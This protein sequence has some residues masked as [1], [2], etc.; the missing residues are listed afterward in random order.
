MNNVYVDSE[1][2]LN[3]ALNLKKDATNILTT[4]QNECS[5]AITAGN[6]C[7]RVSGLDSSTINASLNKIFTKA[8]DQLML[9]ANFLATNVAQEYDLT[10]Q[11]IAKSFN[12]EFANE[13]ASLLGITIG[14]VAGGATGIGTNISSSSGIIG[15]YTGGSGGSYPSTGSQKT[16]PYPNGNQTGQVNLTDLTAEE[17]A[18]LE[19][20][21]Y[22]WECH[23]G[24][25]GWYKTDPNTGQPILA[26]SNDLNKMY[27]ILGADQNGKYKPTPSTSIN[28]GMTSVPSNISNSNVTETIMMQKGFTKDAD[29]NWVNSDGV[30]VGSGDA[31]IISH[32]YNRFLEN[33]GGDINSAY[34]STQALTDQLIKASANGEPVL[35]RD[36]AGNPYVVTDSNFGLGGNTRNS[37]TTSSN[38]SSH[39]SDDEYFRM[40]GRS[41][42]TSS[43]ISS[44]DSAINANSLKQEQQEYKNYTDTS[45]ANYHLG[46]NATNSHP[47]LSNDEYF[48]MYGRSRDTSSSIS[49]RDSAINAN[50]LK[51]E[52]QEYKNY[53]DTSNAN[54]HLGG[55]ATNSHPYLSNDEYFRMYGRSRDTSSS[56][57]SRDS[58]INANSM[59]QEQMASRSI[60][61]NVSSTKSSYTNEKMDILGKTDNSPS[62]SSKSSSSSNQHKS[63]FDINVGS[64]N[65]NS[66]SK[67]GSIS[68]SSSSMSSTTTKPTTNAKYSSGSSIKTTPSTKTT[69]ISSRDSAINANSMRNEQRAART[70]SKVYDSSTK[71]NSKWA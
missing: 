71:S 2:L 5:H 67:R 44:R 62:F 21:G 27:G 37:D 29:G 9:L 69:S 38:I 51:Q 16:S 7:L 54:Y 66:S 46:G 23:D 6:E 59:K 53:T 36:A 15:G 61:T 60:N 8:Y 32:E 45:N 65:S 41:R 52:Q 33:S 56:I 48:R 49:S 17:K 12:Q 58:A 1:Q 25:C 43:S 14:S 42:D 26:G 55:N 57:S 10:T 24:T 4:F 13:I 22:K 31:E 18:K 3:C 63:I 47:Y 64:N 28:G 20:A 68:S 70:T 39:L 40:Y 11:A 30:V 19:A 50:S 34:N 35:K